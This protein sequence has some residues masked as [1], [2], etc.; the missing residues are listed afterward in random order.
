M[1]STTMV[2]C[3]TD[4]IISRAAQVT[5]ENREYDLT[6]DFPVVNPLSGKHAQP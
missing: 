6:C 2:T 3:D 4:K 5:F 1:K